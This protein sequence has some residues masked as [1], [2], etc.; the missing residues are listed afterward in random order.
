[1]GR[2]KF[3]SL[4]RLQWVLA[5]FAVLWVGIMGSVAYVAVTMRLNP[6][7]VALFVPAAPPPA[8]GAPPAAATAGATIQHVDS[9]VAGLPQTADP[10][11]VATIAGRTGIPA[12]AMS[13]Y[14]D[15]ELTM[16]SSDPGCHLSWNML[17]GIGLIESNHG[18]HA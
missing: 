14:A 18:Q 5:G 10:G 6:H 8:P 2:V 7:E 16:K 15:A 11:W 12:R 9:S 3:P 17:A 1:M 13:A 4:S